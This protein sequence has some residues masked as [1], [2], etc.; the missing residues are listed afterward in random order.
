MLVDLQLLTTILNEHI[1]KNWTSTFTQ[2]QQQR[3]I[4]RVQRQ[5]ETDLEQ[6]M[7]L[8]KARGNLIIGL[9]I[10]RLWQAAHKWQ[11]Y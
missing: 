11:K 5:R 2:K 10:Y 9:H 1:Y 3:A 6:K 4:A 7:T 8:V